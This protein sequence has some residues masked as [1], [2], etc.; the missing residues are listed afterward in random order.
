MN[1]MAIDRRTFLHGL[2]LAGLAGAGLPQALIAPALAASPGGD[3]EGQSR[4]LFFT[5]ARRGRGS[6]VFLVLDGGGRIVRELP[7]A[8]RG[9]DCVVHAQS[10]R[11]VV[12]ARRPGTFAVAFHIEDASPPV[13][14]TARPDRHFYGHGVF[15][16]DGRLLYATENDFDTARGVIGVYDVAAGYKRI[17]E[18]DSHGVGPHDLLLAPDGNTLVVANGG[19]ETHPEAGRAKLNIESMSPSLVFIDRRSGDLLAKHRLGGELHK[20]SIRHLDIDASGRV[21]FGGQWE[22][23]L[24]A[25]PSLVGF[26]SRDDQLRLVAAVAPEATALRGYIGSVA[27]DRS[28]RLL[29]A[30]APRAGRIL[31]I[32]TDRGVIAG[33]TALVDGCGVAPS[34]GGGFVASSGEGDLQ[35]TSAD[36]SQ[37]LERYASIAFD[38]HMV[39]WSHAA[40]RHY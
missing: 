2:T 3:T 32:D 4:E 19:I 7:L 18:F 12:F 22:G 13:A 34:A 8:A 5:S 14:F 24:N 39:G 9:H 6:Y 21:W 26:A 38:N 17:G 28:G 40:L 31:Y 11:G 30:S 33:E 23:G 37:P 20:L 35:S 29:A 15:S 10:G 1:S 36:G 25:A 27:M 16:P